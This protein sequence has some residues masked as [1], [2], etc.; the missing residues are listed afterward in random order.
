MAYFYFFRHDTN[1]NWLMKEV[2]EVYPQYLFDPV[3]YRGRRVKFYVILDW[4]FRVNR[5]AN[6]DWIKEFGGN[7]VRS[8]EELP[9]GAG[10][11]ITGY[12]SD[13][14]ELQQARE[15]G[16][17]IIDRACPW[18]RQFRKQLESM[19]TQTEQAAIM[20]DKGH[21]VYDCY[22]SIF[23]P[24][25]IFILPSNYKEE[26][27]AQKDPA[28]SLR[29]IVYTVFR[30]KD[31]ENAERFIR[32]HYPH[33]DNNLEGYKKS[34]CVWTKQ[35]LVEEMEEEIPRYNLEQIWIICSSEVDRSTKSL[36]NEAREHGCEARII[37]HRD[38]IPASVAA[39]AR[40]GVL[41]A[42][43]PMPKKAVEIK[44]IIKQR[45]SRK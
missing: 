24:D 30:K 44:E 33:P 41:M 20:I 31:A 6:M 4:V 23:P 36:I 5:G 15:R 38:D 17:P 7:Y 29:L 11:F 34:L 10:I 9:Q 37:K 12:D 26:I 40:V 13:V 1:C 22:K 2:K 18:V 25:S 45:F 39:D 27:P 3:E 35:G 43:I 19:N 32:E 14:R 28:K 21:M 42:P 8:F 16:I